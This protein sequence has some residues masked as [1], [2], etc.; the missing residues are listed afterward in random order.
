MDILRDEGEAYGSKL[1]TAGIKVKSRRH[2][3][4]PHHF[5]MMDGILKSAMEY[6]REFEE[7]LKEAF[8]MA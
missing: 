8:S 7:A 1:M 3:G 6:N 2:K 4:M 5:M